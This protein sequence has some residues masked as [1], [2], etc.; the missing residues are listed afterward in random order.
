MIDTCQ[1]IVNDMI[2][3]R[4][5]H[6]ITCL[7]TTII[8]NASFKQSYQFL[9][10]SNWWNKKKPSKLSE[11]W[12]QIE[13]MFISLDSGSFLLDF[14]FFEDQIIDKP[15]IFIQFRIRTISEVHENNWIKSSVPDLLIPE[16][17]SVVSNG[18]AVHLCLVQCF[19]LWQVLSKK[20]HNK[21]AQIIN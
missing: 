15:I 5:Q 21:L 6:L 4:D 8:K 2:L 11:T 10:Y 13:S 7:C 20:L 18:S 1:S 12:Y 14:W 19:E 9:T 17:F 3:V 16:K